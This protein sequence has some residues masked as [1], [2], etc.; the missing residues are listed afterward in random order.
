M[1]KFQHDQSLLPVVRAIRR[2]KVVTGLGVW[3]VERRR[4][5]CWLCASWVSWPPEI[6][7]NRYGVSR[8]GRR[9]K[10]RFSSGS[11]TLCCWYEDYLVFHWTPT[12]FHCY[13]VPHGI[14]WI[15]F[16]WYNKEFIGFQSKHWAPTE[17]AFYTTRPFT[18]RGQSLVVEKLLED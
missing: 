5:Q 1:L 6:V 3:C 7:P 13:R 11:L 10:R 18:P 8:G 2:V 9:K 12:Y 14:S 4:H 16:W 15:I 17:E